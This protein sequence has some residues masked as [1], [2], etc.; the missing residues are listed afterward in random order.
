MRKKEHP[1]FNP[2][3]IPTL[4]ETMIPNNMVPYI[5]FVEWT[6]S[7]LGHLHI[8]H[9]KIDKHVVWNQNI[10]EMWACVILLLLYIHIQYICYALYIFYVIDC[11]LCVV[12]LECGYAQLGG[13][14]LHFQLG[15]NC[16]PVVVENRFYKSVS[17]MFLYAEMN[18]LEPPTWNDWTGEYL[19]VHT[20][21]EQMMKNNF[22]HLSLHQ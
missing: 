17:I 14:F 10:N 15:L 13:P 3:I 9:V 21:F 19:R 20:N 4:V 6:S 2:I 18:I 1:W 5:N 11:G 16:W 7:N 22:H 8:D 12:T